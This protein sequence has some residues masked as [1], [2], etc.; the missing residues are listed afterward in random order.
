MSILHIAFYPSDWLA[1]TRGLSDAET[2]VYITLIA[3]MYEMAGPIDRDDERLARLCGSKSRAS[4]VKSLEHL[5]SEGK[6]VVIGK[7]LFNDR[8]EKEIK[9]TTEKSSK[10]KSA[11][12]SRWKKK[13]NKNNDCACAD[14]SPKHMPQPCQLEPEL[15]EKEEPKGSSKKRTRKPE[16]ELPPGWVPNNTNIEHAL[17][18]GLT[19]SEIDHEAD[20]FRN[21]HISKG[22]R[23]RD[24]DAA[25]RTWVGNAIKFRGGGGMAGKAV[26]PRHGQGSSIASIVARRRSESSL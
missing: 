22:N 18:K 8:V 11:A 4:F 14:A 7:Q 21:N 19:A 13:P 9:N 25:W 26:S 2:G 24:W 20:Q 17:S 5:I 10:A 6:I 1:G 12:Q 15:E 23:F 3:R 16:V